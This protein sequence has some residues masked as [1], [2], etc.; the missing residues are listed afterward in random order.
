MKLK[1]VEGEKK[2]V[3]LSEGYGF[4]TS[5]QS[6]YW[7]LQDPDVLSKIFNDSNVTVYGLSLSGLKSDDYLPSQTMT[8]LERERTENLTGIGF[9]QAYLRQLSH[10][11]GG[12]SIT[13]TN[14]MN[15]GLQLI[16][17]AMSHS[18]VLGYTPENRIMDGKYRK[19]EVKVKRKGLE[20][21]HRRGYFASDTIPEK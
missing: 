9:K 2:V 3:L 16:G 21:R 14:D 20:V 13:N 12:I 10:D 11:T 6:K 17:K 15:E 1:M 5:P 19:I 4:I 7:E 18:Y 8:L